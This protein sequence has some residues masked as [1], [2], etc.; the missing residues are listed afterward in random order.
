MLRKLML[1]NL[2]LAVLLLSFVAQ[3]VFSRYVLEYF[4]TILT[5]IVN[6][7][8]YT[9]TYYD[10]DGNVFYR[11]TEYS[12]QAHTPIELQS[13]ASSSPLVFQLSDGTTKAMELPDGAASFDCWVTVTD[14]ELTSI[15]QS[16]A[17]K[18]RFTYNQAATQTF[19][20]TYMD[21]NGTNIV[22]IIS[23]DNAKTGDVY[24]HI[25]KN[26]EQAGV[27][28]PSTTMGEDPINAGE[29]ILRPDL[30]PNYQAVLNMT[31]YGMNFAY[32]EVRTTNNDNSVTITKWDEYILTESNVVVYPYYVYTDVV[33]FR[34]VDEEGNGSIEYYEVIPVTSLP[35]HVVIPG[36]VNGIP[37][38]NVEKLFNSSGGYATNVKTISL[39]EGIETIAENGLAATPN[40]ATVSLPST[41]TALGSHT[42]SQ[43]PGQDKKELHIIYAGTMAQWDAI[44]DSSP[45]DWDAGLKAGSLLQCSDGYMIVSKAT[46]NDSRWD[47]WVSGSPPASVIPNTSN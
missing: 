6:G 32:W 17:L 23:F 11:H 38:K 25:G 46:G 45:S 35:D 44:Q 2:C 26:P 19:T 7:K 31:A 20:V 42:F 41:L 40:L 15:S 33:G 12:G 21:M 18:P 9:V 43:N 37:V 13:S 24:D 3:P 4:G 14:Q 10:V 16:I 36:N 27:L 22:A 1:A 47:D 5:S 34:G 28:F 8:V 29:T 39:G 30:D